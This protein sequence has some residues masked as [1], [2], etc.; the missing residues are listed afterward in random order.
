MTLESAGV[1]GAR[2]PADQLVFDN[3]SHLMDKTKNW[4]ADDSAESSVIERSLLQRQRTHAAGASDRKLLKLRAQKTESRAT[5]PFQDL[6]LPRGD[7]PHSFQT[8]LET[9]YAAD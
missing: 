3:T 8:R 4:A 6:F 2:E 5:K 7:E 1:A 9:E